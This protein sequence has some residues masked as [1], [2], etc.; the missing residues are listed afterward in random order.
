MIFAKP[1]NISNEYYECGVTAIQ[2][3]ED[4]DSGNIS[5]S[6]YQAQMDILND[7]VDS[8]HDNDEFEEYMIN[9]HIFN[10]HIWSS[11]FVP[12]INPDEEISEL[13]NYTHYW[14]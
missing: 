7:Y 5:M 2:M 11:G 6:E 3:Y 1:L 10:L 12:T 13:R 9:A 4:L 14:F 8:L